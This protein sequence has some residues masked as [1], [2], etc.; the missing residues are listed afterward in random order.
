[1][2]EI[3]QGMSVFPGHLKTIVWDHATQEE[4]AKVMED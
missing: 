4:S 2:Q 3:Y 1:M